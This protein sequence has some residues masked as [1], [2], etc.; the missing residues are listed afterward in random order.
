LFSFLRVYLG[1]M[2]YS[3]VL[4]VYAALRPPFRV[5]L[6]RRRRRRRRRRTAAIPLQQYRYY[7]HYNCT[8]ITIRCR[9]FPRLFPLLYI[10]LSIVLYS[11]VSVG[12]LSAGIRPRAYVYLSRHR[13]HHLHHP[14][15]AL[16]VG[17]AVYYIA[18]PR[19]SSPSPPRL[20]GVLHKFVHTF[21][22]SL[23]RGNFNGLVFNDNGK[24]KRVI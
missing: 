5:L 18:A 24:C 21:V 3:F 13:H 12:F 7:Y 8:T 19:H 16:C 1:I 9:P 22:L 23:S 6:R 20:H 11:R 15:L 14:P 17:A 2:N 4:F 10:T